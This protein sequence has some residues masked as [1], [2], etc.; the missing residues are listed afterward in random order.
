[1]ADPATG[2]PV[3]ANTPFYN[4]SIGKGATSTIAHVL[5]EC[6]V[7]SYDTSIVELWPESVPTANRP[8]LC[9]TC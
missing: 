5:A 3:T 9:G 1:M 6:G 4:F 2:R 7:F 8:S